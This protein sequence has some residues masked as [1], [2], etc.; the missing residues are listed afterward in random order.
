MSDELKEA[1]QAELE[2]YEALEA[3]YSEKLKKVKAITR[4]LRKMADSMEEADED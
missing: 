2:K 1:M 3:E 4:N